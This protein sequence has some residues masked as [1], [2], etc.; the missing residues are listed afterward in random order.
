VLGLRERCA[1][2]YDAAAQ[3]LEAGSHIVWGLG[4]AGKHAAIAAA[5]G[6]HWDLAERHFDA[7]TERAEAIRDRI[8]AADLLR[9]RAQARLWR[10]APGDRAE[11]AGLA[12]AAR[13]A[14]AAIGMKRHVG[15]AE[16][17]LESGA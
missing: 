9:W 15:L 3:L 13:D 10:D 1:A 17:L 4:M 5:A 7:A 12:Q 2:L 16:A 6:G 11:A 8:D 14:Y